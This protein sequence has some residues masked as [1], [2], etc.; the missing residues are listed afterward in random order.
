VLAAALGSLLYYGRLFVTGLLPPSP[1]VL[2]GTDRRPAEPIRLQG[3][4]AFLDARAAW[5]RNRAAIA[6]AVV[7]VLASVAVAVSGGGLGVREAAA[8]LPPAEVA[9]GES[10]TP[11]NPFEEPSPAPGQSLDP[12][13][14]TGP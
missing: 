9:P 1:A 12:R 11:A 8:G 6:G 5:S 14:S 4:F 13:S 7:L 3:R 10:L 2:A